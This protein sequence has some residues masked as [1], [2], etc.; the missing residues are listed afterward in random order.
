MDYDVVVVGLGPVGA[1]AANLAGMWGLKTLAVDR[2]PDI[3]D[4]PRA[5][6]LDQEV[7]RVF[8]NIG[9]AQQIADVVMPYRTSEYRAAGGQVLKRIAP[10]SPPYLLGWAPNYVFNQPAVEHALRERLAACPSVAFETGVEVVA[11]REEEGRALVRLRDSDGSEREVGARF[12]LACDGGTSPLRTSLG[13]PMEDL[14]FDEP[15]MVVDVH[16]TPEAAQRLPQTNVQFCEPARPCS[17]IVGPGLHRRWEFMINDDE[18]PAGIQQPESIRTLLSRWLAPDEYRLWRASSYRFHALVLESWRKDNVFFLGDAAHMTPPF[19]A[20]GM[21]Q[22]IRDAANLV[23]KLALVAHDAAP[24]SLLDSY[25]EERKPH[26]RHTTL[27]TK[28]LGTVI[29]ERD[30]AKARERDERLLAEMAQASGPTVR[31]SLIPGLAGGFLS[32][33]GVGGVR[34]V[35]F[36]QPQVED[37]AGRTGLLDA[38]AQAGFLV[39]ASREAELGP[40]LAELGSWSGGAMPPEVLRLT[41]RR[42]DPLADQHTLR[43]RDGLLN[44]W[45]ARHGCSVVVVRPDHYVYGGAKDGSEAVAV[46]RALRAALDTRAVARRAA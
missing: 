9:I 39:V 25:E 24:A 44:D 33:V 28:E 32:P 21:C 20:Q 31:Q 12:V 5:F 10:A 41:D 14:A 38:F 30:A 2:L 16:V 45:F 40:L 18:T 1:V 35:L 15:W 27:V 36:P 42:D 34:G 37:H 43:E 6:G 22:G 29:C 3:Y 17:Y 7:M 8:D 23:W 4:K 46:L 26:V 11:V 13:L 19:M